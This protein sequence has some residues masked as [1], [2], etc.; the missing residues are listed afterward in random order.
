MSTGTD[1]ADET[2]ESPPADT[3]AQLEINISNTNASSQT[4]L[5]D[6]RLLELL[7]K[8]PF[9]FS[10]QVPPVN[11][12][13]YEEWGWE[14]V[15]KAF[16]ESYE[17]IPLSAPF[18]IAEL[19]WRWDILRPLVNSLAR[20]KGQIP[21]PMWKVVVTV[22]NRLNAEKS[23]ESWNS[24]CQD[25]VLSQLP[26][27]EAL[28]HNQRLHLEVEFMDLIL[29]E[30]R[31]TKALHDGMTLKEVESVQSDYS[32]FFAAIK[33]KELPPDTLLRLAMEDGS[34]SPSLS[35]KIV[36]AHET[37]LVISSV[38]SSADESTNGTTEPEIKTE[39]I[40][41]TE[42]EALNPPTPVE[43]VPAPASKQNDTQANGG[44]PSPQQGHSTPNH[45]VRMFGFG[46]SRAT[47]QYT[48]LLGGALDSSFQKKCTPMEE[49]LPPTKTPL[50]S[51]YL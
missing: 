20:A 6:L 44:A 51:V 8:Y 22:N 25:L 16:N 50:T 34:S 11:D 27:V 40:D 42:A 4:V 43:E 28:T 17:G 36:N 2:G 46:G 41:E 14:Q 9:L 32:Q 30:E 10:R 12:S 47:L 19:Q 39:P 13:D 37:D 24:K 33:V 31:R 35:P 1:T 18:T 5:N 49:H 23:K 26:F 3:M 38:F 45:N 29:N 15:A 7:C 48:P 21:E